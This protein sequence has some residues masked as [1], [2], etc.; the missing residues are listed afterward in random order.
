MGRLSSKINMAM[1]NHHFLRGDTS[2]QMVFPIVML[3]FKGVKHQSRLQQRLA[4]IG[5]W[6]TPLVFEVIFVGN[7]K[8]LGD[9][10]VYGT[11]AL[12]W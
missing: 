9:R 3:V 8:I 11:L 2:T 1:E 5:V 10:E 12:R 7:F 4:G 6:I